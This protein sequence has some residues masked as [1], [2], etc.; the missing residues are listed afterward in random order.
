MTCRGWEMQ[1]RLAGGFRGTDAVATN[2]VLE[3]VSTA[4]LKSIE[5][6]QTSYHSGR[7]A[8][9]V[10]NPRCSP[11]L[12]SVSNVYASHVEVDK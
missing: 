2:C 11:T 3:H 10:S 8:L 4:F 1:A 7:E 9:D 6:A 5:I 12:V